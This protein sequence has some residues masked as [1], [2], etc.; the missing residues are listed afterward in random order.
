MAKKYSDETLERIVEIIKSDSYTIAEICDKVGISE[1]S[2]Y[3][4]QK[5]YAEFAEAIKRA[6]DKFDEKC[7]IEAKRSLIKLV[8][9]YTVDETKTVYVDGKDGKPKIKEQTI[10]KK[11]IQPNLG[12]TIFLLTNKDPENWK[13][14]QN[15]E[16]TAE[17]GIKS[18][19]ESLSNEQLQK[20]IDGETE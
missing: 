1:R 3:N 16:I 17:V 9:G 13:N 10:T 19:L 14:R 7:V 20:I 5:E 4:Y 11:H 8:G 15:S 12:A 2:F 6:R 18:H